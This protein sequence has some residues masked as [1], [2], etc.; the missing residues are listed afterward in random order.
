MNTSTRVL[1]QQY[2]QPTSLNCGEKASALGR[3][4]ALGRPTAFYGSSVGLC[5]EHRHYS[6]CINSCQHFFRKM[7]LRRAGGGIGSSFLAL[8]SSLRLA[9]KQLVCFFKLGYTQ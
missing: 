3:P 8:V 6:R 1:A 9:S 7:L 4:R 5:L 2:Q